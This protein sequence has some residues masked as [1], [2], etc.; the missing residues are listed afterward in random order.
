MSAARIA[1]LNDALRRT[2]GILPRGVPG[3]A[4]LTRALVA[5]PADTQAHVLNAVRTF[6]R[7]TPDNDPWHEH[8]GA[9]LEV[10]GHA[11]IW[12]VDYYADESCTFGSEAPEDPA[13]SYR[14]LTIMLASDY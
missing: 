3:R 4:V 6:D 11:I 9:R 7:F 12:K 13:R 2:L 10:D 5:L 8:D 1:A 14:V